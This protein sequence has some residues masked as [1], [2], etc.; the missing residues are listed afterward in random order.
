MIKFFAGF[1]LGGV[2]TA[3]ILMACWI[4]GNNDE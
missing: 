3:V 1:F 2:I 4:G